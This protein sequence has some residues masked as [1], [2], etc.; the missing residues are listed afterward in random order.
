VV[1]EDPAG[2]SLMLGKLRYSFPSSHSLE[3]QSSFDREMKI[4]LN[5]IGKLTTEMTCN[6]QKITGYSFDKKNNML[7][8]KALAGKKYDIDWR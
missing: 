5:D 1:P 8:F 6:G 3:L 4:V 7:K 2:K